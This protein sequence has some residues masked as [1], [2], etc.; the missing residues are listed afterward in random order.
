MTQAPHGTDSSVEADP[1]LC[2]GGS[3][4]F[5]IEGVRVE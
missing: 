4:N 2:A 5:E 1:A 3:I